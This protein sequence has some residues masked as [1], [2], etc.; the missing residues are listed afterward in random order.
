MAPEGRTR[1]RL[2]FDATPLRT[3]R[4]GVGH[5]AH[6]VLAG[7]ATR[8]DVVVSAYASRTG[9]RQLAELLPAG[10]RAAP[11]WLPARVVVPIWRRAPWPRVERWTG[12]VDVV[13]ATNF[14]APPARAPVVVTVHDLTFVTAPELCRPGTRSLVGLLR[15]ALARGATVH[16]VS[17]HVA[18]EFRA[19]FDVSSERV[20]RVYEGVT[21]AV[22]GDA[23]SGHRLAGGDA[24][25]LALGTIEP[26]KNLP[27]LVRAFDAV[28]TDH[29]E[30]LLVV[31][32]P[33]GWGRAAFDA[34]VAATSC[35]PR[36][37]R[38]GYV[39]DRQRADLLAGATLLAYPS[40]DEGFGLPPL[41][42]MA[43]GVPVV[44]AR[45]GALPEVLADA[46]L[47]VDPTDVDDIA[48]TLDRVL[49]DSSVRAQLVSRGSVRAEM[50]PWSS[51]VDN[52]VALYK[53]L[54]Q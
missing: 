25:V 54:A 14:I 28:A 29:P 53:T 37:R 41:E 15:R 18:D 49:T 11:S 24:Y 50:F 5:F 51:T 10:V 43:A 3:A 30:L 32:G 1:I 33:D 4:T 44:A 31:A 42:A 8:D 46:A 36:I 22:D 45:A 39:A 35:A 20:V 40:L 6:Q 23:E 21:P 38:M 12:P 13:H 48:A 16:A 27:M 17:D 7:L 9:R 52:L 19:H 26:R 34:A 2:A 47:L